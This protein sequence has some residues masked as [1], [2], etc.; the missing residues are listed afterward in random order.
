MDNTM[1]DT[2]DNSIVGIPYQNINWRDIDGQPFGQAS[3]FNMF[4]LGDANNI[5]DVEG[6]VAIGGSFYSPRGFSVGFQRG[7]NPTSIGFSPDLARFI[8]GNV[9]STKGPLVVIGHAISNGSFQAGLGSTYYIGNDDSDGQMDQLKQLYQ[10]RGGSPYWTPSDKG[11]YYLIPS[12]DVPRVIPA[13]RIS[14]DLP[15]FFQNARSSLVN[16]RNCISQLASNGTITSNSHEWILTGTDPTQNIFTIDVSPNGL[17]NK[18]IRFNVPR[19]SLAIVRL[20]TGPHAHLQYGVYG[21]KSMANHTLYVF[22]DATNIHM[23]KSSDIWGSILAPQAMFHGHPTGGHVSGNAALGGFA[24]NPNSGFEFHFYP[25]VGGVICGETLP[26]EEVIETPSPV[27]TPPEMP[28]PTPVPT[29]PA[30]PCPACPE[31]EPCPVQLPCPEPEPCPVAPPCPE[32][33]PCPV[34]PPCPTCPEPAPCPVAPPCPTCPEPEPCPVAPPCPTCPTC[35]EPEPC[36][37]AAPCPTCPEPPPCPMCPEPAPCP[38][39]PEPPPCPTCPEC[40]ACPVC[41]EQRAE[42]QREPMGIPIPFPVPIPIRSK[43][44][45]CPKCE[46]CLVTAGMITGCICGCECHRSHEWDVML[47]QMLDGKKVMVSCSTICHM[48]CFEFKV[49]YEGTYI[50]K[51]CPAKR[52]FFSP[53]CRPKVKLTNI[54]VA[55]FIIE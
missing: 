32:P 37:V 22:E 36:P 24:V 11:E 19:G 25:F 4:V 52:T 7:N 45:E 2:Q 21:D 41:P 38:M 10:A 34:A 31:P 48:E 16:Y 26:A 39:C 44:I 51:I 50:L 17:I 12:Y 18:G 1:Y 28:M 43:P 33:P 23:E 3:A 30:Q 5:V 13:S 35:P 49:S 42:T 46:E 40:P 20:K 53:A 27:P 29:Q 15:A 55:N 9:T 54:G 6:A 47:Y 8:T 14:A